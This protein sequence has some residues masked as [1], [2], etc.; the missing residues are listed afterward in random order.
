MKSVSKKV[1]RELEILSCLKLHLSIHL[2]WSS[3]STEN[4][5]WKDGR[6]AEV[7]P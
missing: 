1:M 4:T 7:E 6:K 2:R 5:I 3:A